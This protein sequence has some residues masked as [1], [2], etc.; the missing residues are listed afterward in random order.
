MEKLQKPTV[1][2]PRFN[3]IIPE[4]IRDVAMTCILGLCAGLSAVGFLFVINFIHAHTYAQFVLKSPRYFCI[5]SFVLITTASLLVGLLLTVV[6]RDAAGSGIPQVKTGY[7]KELGFFHIKPLIIKFIAGALSIGG[8][9]SLGREGPSVY[10]GAGIASN[11]SGIFGVPIRQRR[12]ATVVGASAGL[13]AAFNTPIAAITFIIEEIVGDIGNR[14]LGAVVLSSVIGAFA[15]HAV[16]GRSPAFS[17]PE[18]ENIGWFHYLVVPAVALVAAFAGIVFQ[19]ITLALRSSLKK[20]RSFPAWSLPV[21]GGLITWIVGC[22]VFLTTGKA[23]VF[24]LGYA[25]LSNALTNNFEWKIAGIMVLSKLVATI[26]CYGFGGCGG[27]FAPSLYIGAMC[28]YFIGGLADIWLPLTAAD[29][30]VLSAV[31]MSA[32]LGALI[33]APLTSI[34]IVFEMT[35]HFALVPG[36]MLGALISQAVAHHFAKLNFYEA[37]L[38]QDGHELHKIKPPLDLESWRNLSVSIISRSRPVGLRDLSTP[39]MRHMVDDYPY[40]NFLVFDKDNVTGIV[41][42][43]Q[44]V[45]A[46]ASE[47]VPQPQPPVFCYMDQT[48]GEASDRF[49]ESGSQTLIVRERASDTVVGIFTLHDLMRMQ[50]AI[51]NG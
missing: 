42:R 12:G 38:I 41:T 20:Q 23:G 9:C 22:T 17:I 28:G 1:T 4:N 37:L 33:H 15:V 51:N 8:G 7:W 47:S 48:V 24:G 25:D 5:A 26:A 44:L 49:I 30:I 39:T 14:Y 27:I 3:R 50:A 32:C 46:I 13:A 2:K 19:R 36:L 45:D 34:L 6:S 31:G 21:A 18:I 35:H 16:L 10:I 43:K 40:N 29:R 11:V